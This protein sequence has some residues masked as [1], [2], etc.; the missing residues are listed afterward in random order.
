MGGA[1]TL[2]YIYWVPIKLNAL[3]IMIIYVI[4]MTSYSYIRK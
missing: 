1:S 2:L 3:Q 4:L